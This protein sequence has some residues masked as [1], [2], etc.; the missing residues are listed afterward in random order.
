MDFFGRVQPF[1]EGTSMTK[2]RKTACAAAA[3]AALAS[4]STEGSAETFGAHGPP[5]ANVN[6]V[7]TSLP[8]RDIDNPARQPVQVEVGQGIGHFTG[9]AVIYTVPPGKRLVVEHFSSELGV[10]T[11]TAVDR[12][13][14][15]I[16]D[17][18]A[19]IGSASF[20]HTIPPAYHAPCSLCAAGTELWVASQPVRI[21][22]DAGKA[23][24]AT[25][26]FSNAAGPNTFVFFSVSGY[27]VDVP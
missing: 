22:V 2:L 12:Y 5:T 15:A 8:T 3:V 26:T 19:Q 21:Y 14:L 6:V 25:V 10:A 7:N 1:K 18:P 13:L 4:I 9:Q 16:A 27:L 17:N 23:L 20:S 24:F 11:G